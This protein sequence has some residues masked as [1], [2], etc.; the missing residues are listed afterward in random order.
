MSLRITLLLLGRVLPTPFI[1]KIMVSSAILQ[2]CIGYS[3]KI[4][5]KEQVNKASS[6]L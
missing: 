6:G 3:A 2:M 5:N 4:A 1:E